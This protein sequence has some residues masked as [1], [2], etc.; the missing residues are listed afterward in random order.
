MNS[1]IDEKLSKLRKL[2]K[3]LR[4]NQLATIT[5]EVKPVSWIEDTVLSTGQGKALAVILPTSGCYW[6]RSSTGGCTVCGYINDSRLKGNTDPFGDFIVTW[7]KRYELGKGINSVKIF[8]SGSFFDSSEIPWEDA[9][10]ILEFISTKDEIIEIMVESRPEFILKQK[11][12]LDEVKKILGMKKFGVGIGLESS[13]DTIRKYYINKGIG[14]KSYFNALKELKTRD[15]F[16]KTYVLLKPPFISEIEAIK[17]CQQTITSAFQAG[18]RIVSINPCNVHSG[19]V[20]EWL[21]RKNMYNPPRL[22]SIVELF[23]HFE[24]NRVEGV[25]Q[26]EP[27]GAGKVRGPSNC[28]NCN[29]RVLKAIDIAS[30][31]Q[32]FSHL[33]DLDCTCKETWKLELFTEDL[34]HPLLIQDN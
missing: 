27:V 3:N 33:A 12:R 32:D 30:R 6:A 7:K 14:K 29:D 31:T 9:L 4:D 26:C 10:K 19:T 2:A 28:R 15:F 16:A 20:V 8:N 13:N 25:I 21:W 17:D 5:R 11:D 24:K 1:D 18:S 23:K 22:W 34:A